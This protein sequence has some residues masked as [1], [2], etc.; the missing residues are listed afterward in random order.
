MK[1]R[2]QS[3]IEI[4][5]AIGL[6]MVVMTGIVALLINTIGAKT[7]SYD[8]NKSVEL[9]QVVMEGVIYN[10]EV[11]P[12]SFWDLNSSYWANLRQSQ[13]DANFPDYSYSLTPTVYSGNGCSAT[14]TEC[15]NVITRVTWKNGNIDDRFNRFFSRR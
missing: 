15:I 12:T 6:I 10:K 11:N 2:G 14:V 9:S 13:I 5:F 4:V 8:R 3:L 7:K 1:N